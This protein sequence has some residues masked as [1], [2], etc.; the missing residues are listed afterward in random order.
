MVITDKNLTRFRQW[1]LARGRVDGT[2]DLYCS[3]LRKAADDPKGLTHRL[4]AGNLAPNTRHGIMAALRAWAAFAK[5]TALAETLGDIR[6]PPAR[7]IHRKIPLDLEQW[8]KMVRHLRT[9]P[10]RNEAVRQVLLV[11]ALRG[12]RCGDVLRLKRTEIRAALDSGKL[13]YEGKGRKRMEFAAAMI[14]GPLQALSEQPGK[15]ERVRDLVSKS[16]DPKVASVRVWRA[17][18]ATAKEAGILH[19]NPHR[20]RHTFATNF[21]AE[22]KGDP[23]AIVKLQRFMGWENMTTAAR[24]VEEIS[25]DELDAIGAG[26]VGDLLE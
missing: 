2:A 10:M 11:M 17:A 25:S 24:Y 5:D 9:C 20:Y 14:R 16:A 13:P 8:R 6:L 19:M 1:V 7:R 12:L 18:R 23:N 22:L 21:L 4:V 3:H 26:M 15:W